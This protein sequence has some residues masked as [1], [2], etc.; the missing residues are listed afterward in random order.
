MTGELRQARRN[1]AL[2]AFQASTHAV[3][4]VGVEWSFPRDADGVSQQKSRPLP[5]GFEERLCQL[6]AA[7]EGTNPQSAEQQQ[8]RGGRFRNQNHKI[9]VDGRVQE[10]IWIT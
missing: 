4:L 10:V 9:V 2:P 5:G 1:H 8:S 6:T 3:V 7:P